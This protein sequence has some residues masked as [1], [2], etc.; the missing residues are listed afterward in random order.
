MNAETQNLILHRQSTDIPINNGAEFGLEL[1]SGIKDYFRRAIAPLEKRIAELE[2]RPQV[3]YQGVY[4]P[5]AEYSEGALV[6]RDG[7]IFHANRTTK[8]MPGDGNQDWTLAV[9]RGQDG[10]ST[11]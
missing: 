7:S 6:T 9:K 5:G 8:A 2:S 11:R 1:A 10:K 3:K 4:R